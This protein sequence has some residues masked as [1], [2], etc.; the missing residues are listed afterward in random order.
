ME[1]SQKGQHTIDAAMLDMLAA[2]DKY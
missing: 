1:G 2:Y